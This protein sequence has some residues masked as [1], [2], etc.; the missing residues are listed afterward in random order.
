MARS[1]VVSHITVASKVNAYLKASSNSPPQKQHSDRMGEWLATMGRQIGMVCPPPPEKVA[2]PLALVH[3][4]VAGVVQGALDVMEGATPLTSS[5]ALQIQAALVAMLV[6]GYQGSPL[7][8]SIIKT[9]R[10]PSRVS[11]RGFPPSLPLSSSSPS[12]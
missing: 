1:H 8:L 11:R 7:R 10:H 6:T 4:W 9:L 3:S 12:L 5:S 2:P